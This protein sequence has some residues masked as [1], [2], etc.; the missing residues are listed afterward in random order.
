MSDSAVTSSRSLAMLP[1]Q[2]LE[3]ILQLVAELPGREGVRALLS[4]ARCNRELREAIRTSPD[5]VWR[6]ALN[7]C[8]LN[9][10]AVRL[11]IRMAPSA[12]R[13]SPRKL[14]NLLRVTCARA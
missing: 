5:Q 11:Y 9:S 7:S 2:V 4:I 8:V 3:K 12:M 10:P 6:T 1:H 13:S 14:L